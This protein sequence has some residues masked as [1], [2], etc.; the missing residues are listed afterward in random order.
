[1]IACHSSRVLPRFALALTL[2]QNI[3]RQVIPVWSLTFRVAQRT[4]QVG[5]NGLVPCDS[6]CTCWIPNI[7]F[8]PCALMH[9]VLLEGLPV[10]VRT[11]N[12]H[13]VSIVMVSGFL[14]G[15]IHDICAEVVLYAHKCIP[16]WRRK[17]HSMAVS[18]R[19][20]APPYRLGGGCTLP[21]AAS[22]A[23]NML[24]QSCIT[25]TSELQSPPIMCSLNHL[26]KG[27]ACTLG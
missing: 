2:T 5:H 26:I 27:T 3:T 1:M 12:S 25:C 13:K 10:L 17:Q 8:L 14:H 6:D 4:K 24:S 19:G 20:W 23:G 16:V 9:A 18:L 21:S 22:P 11:N 15:I 7:R